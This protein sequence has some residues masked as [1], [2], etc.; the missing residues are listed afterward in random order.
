MA[1]QLALIG[2]GG[3]ALSLLDILPSPL[4]T[5]GYV[6]FTANGEMPLDYLGDDAAFLAGRTP[7]EWCVAITLVSGQSC[8]L[9]NRARIISRYAAYDSP[10]IIA[11]TAVVSPSAHIGKG[12]A[13]FHRAVL[14][15]RAAIG[16][17][18]IINTGAI[19]EHEC[20]IG[21]NVFI[22]PGTVICGGVKIGDNT[23]I[24][25]GAI[26]KPCTSICSGAIIGAGAVIVEDISEGGTYAGVPAKRL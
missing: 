20:R 17:H 14:N 6:D 3:H 9:G 8:R 12:T 11:P 13:V 19:I 5:T 26:V 7:D 16:C 23:Y 1:K 2:G 18:S 25:A 15:A 21:D 24:G 10:V 4:C 22:G